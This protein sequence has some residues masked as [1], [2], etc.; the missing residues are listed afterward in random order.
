MRGFSR[1]GVKNLY[2]KTTRRVLVF[3]PTETDHITLREENDSLQVRAC[4]TSLAYMYAVW[5]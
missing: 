1:L 2:T 4:K 5:Y 3:T